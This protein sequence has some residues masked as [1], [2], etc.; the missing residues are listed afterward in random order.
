MSGGQY[1][2]FAAFPAVK[3]R[4]CNAIFLAP[5]ARCARKTV[6][7]ANEPPFFAAIREAAPTVLGERN[8]AIAGMKFADAR[9]C[10]FVSTEDDVNC[11][12]DAAAATSDDCQYASRVLGDMLDE[13][14]LIP[15]PAYTLEVST[16]GTADCLSKDRE[17]A[18]FKG[19][20]VTVTTSEMFKQKSIFGG[21]LHERTDKL[22]SINIKGRILAIP[23]DIVLAVRLA[24]AK[25]EPC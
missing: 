2:A 3:T 16:P 22:L 4:L 13:Q 7:C 24:T 14:D 20:E 19:F 21:T 5:R 8:L 17:F 9:L 12:P 6:Y 23:R 1:T 18:V 11:V 15:L 10:I 25:E